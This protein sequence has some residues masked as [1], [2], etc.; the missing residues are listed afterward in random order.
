MNAS[1]VDCIGKVTVVAKYVTIYVRTIY[2]LV[3][4]PVKEWSTCMSKK[5]TYLLC[6][7]IFNVSNF[8]ILCF[9]RYLIVCLKV[10]DVAEKNT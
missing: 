4:G 1:I 2:I 3:F 9:L 7:Y 10:S 6:I 5:K 8:Y